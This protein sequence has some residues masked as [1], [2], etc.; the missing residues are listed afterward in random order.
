MPPKGTPLS[1]GPPEEEAACAG[2]SDDEATQTDEGMTWQVAMAEEEKQ[3][4]A[5]H[6]P[7]DGQVCKD[8]Y[9]LNIN[10]LSA[11]MV[12][13]IRTRLCFIAIF[14]QVP[15]KLGVWNSRWLAILHNKH[16]MPAHGKDSELGAIMW[17]MQWTCTAADIVV[18]TTE[19]KLWQ[20]LGVA[21]D[22]GIGWDNALGSEAT[23]AQMDAMSA[24]WKEIGEERI[25]KVVTLIC[26]AGKHKQG[27]KK[28][29]DTYTPGEYTD[30]ELSAWIISSNY[31]DSN[32]PAL[33]FM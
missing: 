3:W 24:K 23:K 17:P 14:T 4:Y 2:G 11:Y 26:W 19:L 31:A 28:L 7:E 13:L 12:R 22:R 16:L 32:D 18:P 29:P 21:M 20:L 1:L 5:T 10:T 30:S 6:T 8:T 27:A 33:K 25:R 9:A 15:Y